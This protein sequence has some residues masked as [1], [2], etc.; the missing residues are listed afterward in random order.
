MI[1]K[2]LLT[3]TL[4]VLSLSTLASVNVKKEYKELKAATEEKIEV[5]DKKLEKVGDKVS[6]LSGD[7]K[8]EMKERYE[9]L[10]EMKD[11]LKERL[12]DAGDATSNTWEKTKDRVEDYAD[13]LESKIDKAIN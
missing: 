4:F 11:A 1:K 13:D 9:D 3:S 5:M 2:T 10:L 8:E 12:A 6:S 7:A